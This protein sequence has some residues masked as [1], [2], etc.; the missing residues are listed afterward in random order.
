[1]RHEGAIYILAAEVHICIHFVGRPRA[2][3]SPAPF[4]GEHA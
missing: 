3:I 4:K 1:L 2:P